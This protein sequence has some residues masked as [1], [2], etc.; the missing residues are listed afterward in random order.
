M[1]NFVFCIILIM[2]STLLSGQILLEENFE[3]TV[4]PPQGWTVIDA[5]G[6]GYNWFSFSEQGVAHSGTKCAASQSFVNNVGALT[7]D[8]YLISPAVEIPQEGA[9]ILSYYVAAQDQEWP[10]DY[11]SLMVS[12]SGLQL[13][14]F[15][16]LFYETLQSTEWSVRHINLSAF[17]GQTIHIAF[18][19]H[20]CSDWFLLKLDDILISAYEP[21]PP[22]PAVAVSPLNN[23]QNVLENTNLVWSAGTGNAPQGYKL[24]FSTNQDNLGTEHDLGLVTQWTPPAL[25]YSTTYYWKVIPYNEHGDAEN[26]PIWSFTVRDEPTQT[27]I[28]YE[29]FEGTV[30]PPANWTMTDADGD[31]KNWFLFSDTGVAHTGTKCAASQ[32]YVNN[33]GAL[34]PDNYLITP[35]IQLPQATTKL[36]YYVAAQDAQYPGEHYSVMISTT[37]NNISSFTSLFSE[38]LQN[39]QW[40]HREINLS[41]YSGQSVHIA[42]RHHNCT[43]MFIIKL[44]EIKISDTT[45]SSEIVMN[46][47]NTRLIGNYPNPFNPSTLISF[48]IE[49]ND[50]VVLDIYNVKGQ[51]VKSLL[52]EHLFKGI[53]NIEWSGINDKGESVGSGIYFYNLRSGRHSLTGKMILMK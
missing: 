28:F 30:F 11:Y 39:G 15:S 4:F 25:L 19:H 27:I 18:R 21:V 44:D 31:G 12:N 46:P 43:D 1:K 42:F 8:N 14:N 41:A 50:Y 13:E 7:P 32:S 10:N 37:N 35:L 3:N 17:A 53:H 33:L 38:T 49:N 22:L 20:N 36:S 45:S 5:D 23:A 29:G 40:Q 2:F 52:N 16:V 47:L 9:Y 26:C 34:T 6:D 48:E 51:K 24:Y